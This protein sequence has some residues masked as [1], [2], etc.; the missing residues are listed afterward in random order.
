MDTFKDK[1]FLAEAEKLNL[2]INVPQTADDIKKLVDEAYATPARTF[3]S[4]CARS[5]SRAAESKAPDATG[6]KGP[7]R[8]AFFIIRQALQCRLMSG[9]K[10]V[11][12]PMK[13]RNEHSQKT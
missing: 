1:D 11:S 8:A 6:R 2:G 12:T 7:H 9:R 10:T 5:P 3:S 13:R 4:A